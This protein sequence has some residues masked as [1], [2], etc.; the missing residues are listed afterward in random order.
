MITRLV[1]TTAPW[2]SPQPPALEV[3]YA[4]VMVAPGHGVQ[5]QADF[6][7]ARQRLDRARPSLA[8]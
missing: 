2:T 3:A 5:W 6:S 4:A 1:S 8:A 7:S